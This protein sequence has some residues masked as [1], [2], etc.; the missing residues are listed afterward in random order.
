[1]DIESPCN[2]EVRKIYVNAKKCQG[3]SANRK[4]IFKGGINLSEN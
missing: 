1:M 4:T 3:P 2:Q